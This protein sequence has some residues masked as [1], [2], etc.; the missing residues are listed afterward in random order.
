MQIWLKSQT[1]KLNIRI[2]QNTLDF[3]VIYLKV[4]YIL[5]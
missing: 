5:C 3:E 4:L 1:W 2:I